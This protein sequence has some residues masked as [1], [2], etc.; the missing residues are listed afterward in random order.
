MT[1]DLE[2]TYPRRFV[3]PRA[4]PGDWAQIEP[5]FKRLLDARPDSPEALERWLEDGSELFAVLDEERARR[6]TAMTCQT[7]DPERERAYLFYI[8]EIVP[9]LKP[10]AHALNEAYLCFP[11]PARTTSPVCGAWTGRSTIRWPC[12]GLRISPSRPTR[13]G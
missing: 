6:Y 10:L 8:Q 12:S 13:R 5:L 11:V 7:D 2:T 9:R 4:D 3:P 1:V